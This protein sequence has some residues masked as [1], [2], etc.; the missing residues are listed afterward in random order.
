MDNYIIPKAIRP[1]EEFINDLSTWYIRRS[2]DRFKGND[3]QDK[4]FALQ[5]TKFILI[6][7][8][9]P[10]FRFYVKTHRA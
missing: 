2:R 1:I 10:N 5:T 6:E 8:Y 4:K 3:E 7:L 9:Y